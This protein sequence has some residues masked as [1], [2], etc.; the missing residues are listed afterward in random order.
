MANW[1]FRWNGISQ[2]C[3]YSMPYAK[4]ICPK[5][6]EASQAFLVCI[7][8][9]LSIFYFYLNEDNLPSYLTMYRFV[10]NRRY[11]HFH[12]PLK[13]TFPR[14][15]VN[16]IQFLY[17]SMFFVVVE[18]QCRYAWKFFKIPHTSFISSR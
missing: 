10:K 3:L 6:S 12:D 16:T 4:I 8:H 17:I 7:K 5:T 2:Y 1:L 15:C 14:G 18:Y 11:N 9:V 13:A